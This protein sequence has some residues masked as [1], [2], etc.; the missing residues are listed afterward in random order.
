M[1]IKGKSGMKN[2]LNS[3]KKL[4][5]LLGAKDEAGQIKAVENLVRAPV[6][7]ATVILDSRTGQLSV[8]PAGEIP[9]AVLSKMLADARMMVENEIGQAM[10][11]RAMEDALKTGQPETPPTAPEV[12]EQSKTP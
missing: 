2:P 9:A 10:A 12:L 6:F 3:G 5:K 4:A 1:Y 8:S 7:I 11:R